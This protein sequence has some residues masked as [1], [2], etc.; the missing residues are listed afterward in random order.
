MS[1]DEELHEP[2]HNHRAEVG[3][4]GQYSVFIATFILLAAPPL[5]ITRRLR[6]TPCWTRCP[7]S[8]HSCKV[9]CLDSSLPRE[10]SL[11]WRKVKPALLKKVQRGSHYCKGLEPPS[12]QN[13]LLQPGLP[14][15]P[16]PPWTQ[17]WLMWPHQTAPWQKAFL[18][19]KFS[20][21][22]TNLC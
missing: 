7:S 4:P 5:S 12:W 13:L 10:R 21:D 11:E 20:V 15:L 2:F 16:A 8:T 17:P 22:I 6:P 19:S 18:S 1:H 3:V 14:T 9:W